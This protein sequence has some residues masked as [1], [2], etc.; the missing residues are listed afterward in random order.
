[1]LF[2]TNRQQ[3][4]DAVVVTICPPDLQLQRLLARDGM[5]EKEAKQR[6]AAQMPAKDK[7]ARGDFV[8]R[9]DGTK[10]DTDRQVDEVLASLLSS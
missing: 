6:I 1:L 4:F 10:A 9:T 8:I 2:E 3:D 7:A 5:S